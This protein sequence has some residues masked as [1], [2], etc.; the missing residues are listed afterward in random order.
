MAGSSLLFWLIAATLA[1]LACGLIVRRAVAAAARP[2]TEA[3][4]R[5]AVHRRQL[6]ELDTLAERG[7]LSEA[8]LGQARI[9]ASRRLLRAGE[10]RLIFGRQETRVTRLAALAAAAATPLAALGLYAATGS[11]GAADQ[12]HDARVATWRA[13]DPSTL[14]P[15]Q[16]A[17]VLDGLTRERPSDAQAWLF[18]GRARLAGGDAFGALRAFQ[19]AVTLAPNAAAGWEGLG[20]AFT[21]TAQGR[22]DADARRAFA[23]ALRRDP[24]SVTARYQLGRAAQAEGDAARAIALWREAQARLATTDPRRQALGEE[25]ARAEGRPVP[26]AAAAADD[27]A[28]RAMVA[29][30]AARLERSPND[31]A[32]WARLVR[33]Y[34]VLGDRAAA[35]AA[36][37]RARALFA[38]RADALA[39]VEREAP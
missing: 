14:N 35:D 38:G 22:V 26:V 10:Q 33:S 12:P 30:L 8:E 28:I 32:G 29:G 6:E 39:L 1:A 9:E 15:V 17:A 13:S 16:M 36:L 18:L 2:P 37:A 31:P 7:H 27:P 24:T 25:I 23:E 34:R 5:T 3:D 11:P 20:E 21:A 4:P 19:T